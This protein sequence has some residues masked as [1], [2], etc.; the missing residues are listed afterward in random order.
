MSLAGDGIKTRSPK[1]LAGCSIEVGTRLEGRLLKERRRDTKSGQRESAW[2]GT[3]RTQFGS[4]M[5]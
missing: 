2:I 3:L 1:S 4:K 5:I